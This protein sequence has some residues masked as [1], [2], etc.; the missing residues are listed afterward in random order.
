MLPETAAEASVRAAQR[1][2]SQ[3]SAPEAPAVGS[4]REKAGDLPRRGRGAA[5]RGR[6]GRRRTDKVIVLP[7][8]PRPHARILELRSV[9]GELRLPLI[10]GRAP[11]AGREV[12]REPLCSKFRLLHGSSCRP[13]L[14]LA[15]TNSSSCRRSPVISCSA[16]LH[17]KK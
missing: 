10:L 3:N 4:D 8:A 12:A 15:V 17:H 6:T 1:K 14:L 5:R 11:R 13:L 7:D 16:A 2:R 9:H